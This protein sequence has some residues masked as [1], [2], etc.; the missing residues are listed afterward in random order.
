MKLRIVPLMLLSHIAYADGSDFYCHGQEDKTLTVSGR[1]YNGGGS[2]NYS[3]SY[4][5][6]DFKSVK[7]DKAMWT[8]D[9]LSAMI[10]L[11][12]QGRQVGFIADDYF[13]K[14]LKEISAVLMLPVLNTQL[15]CT[16]EFF[17]DPEPSNCN[18]CSWTC[19]EACGVSVP[20]SAGPFPN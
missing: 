2:L 17:Q 10:D 18:K 9:R 14:E 15:T 7:Y 20:F 11:G 16:R 19:I 6:V 8:K 3:D 1:Y 12:P 13:N 4:Q 5:T